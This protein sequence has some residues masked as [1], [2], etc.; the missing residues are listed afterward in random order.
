MV[1]RSARP[2]SKYVSDVP[3]FA[4]VQALLIEDYGDRRADKEWRKKVAEYLRA[5]E[6]KGSIDLAEECAN[7]WFTMRYKTE[8]RL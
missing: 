5:R 4:S 8:D 7:Q 1:R 6:V 2:L 3:T